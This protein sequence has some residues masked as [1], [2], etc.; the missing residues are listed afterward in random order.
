M[1]R[2]DDDLLT[3]RLRADPQPHFQTFGPRTRREFL[4]LLDL[5][6]GRIS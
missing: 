5:T 2:I 4:R 6:G 1:L 3:F